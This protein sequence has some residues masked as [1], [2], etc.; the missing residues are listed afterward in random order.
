MGRIRRPHGVQG[1]VM[2]ESM[3][4][5]EDR[6]AAGSRMR[7]VVGA[8]EGQDA[9]VDLT[10]VDSRR[11][12]GALRV[13]FEELSGRED[14]ETLRGAWLVVDRSIVE[15]PPAG[16]HYF[17]EL[18]GCSC[19]DQELGYIGEVVNVLEDGGGYLLV[20]RPKAPGDSPHEEEILIP[21]VDPLLVEVDTER[22]RIDTRLP[23]GM[24]EICTST[25]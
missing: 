16:G 17:F 22:Q 5:V 7:G 14:A 6:F 20:V 19:H 8:A 3:T 4:D 2:V 18:I 1:E 24:V 12:S 13:S 21:F 25:S 11:H 9:V 10:V 15:P 23:P